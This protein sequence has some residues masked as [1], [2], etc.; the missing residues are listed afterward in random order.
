MLVVVVTG[1][2]PVVGLVSVPV[3]SPAECPPLELCVPGPEVGAV[4][5]VVVP[6]DAGAVVSGPGV[7][8]LVPPSSLHPAASVATSI[9]PRAYRLTVIISIR[10]FKQAGECTTARANISTVW[11]LVRRSAGEPAHVRWL[12]VLATPALISCYSQGVMSTPA[13]PSSLSRGLQLAARGLRIALASPEV[14]RAYVHLAAV[15]VALAVALTVLLGGLLWWMVPVDGDMS[16]TTWLGRWAL[17]VGGSLL[18]LMAA[19]MLALFVVNLG[20]PVLADRVFMAGMRAAAPELAARLDRPTGLGFVAS[21]VGNLRRGLRFL[22]VTIALGALALVPFV[23]PVLG[24]PLQLWYAARTL[25][26]ELLDPYFE[27]AGH[28]YPRQRGIVAA[29]RATLAGFGLPWAALM[30]LPLLGPLLFGLAQAAV[31]ALV[32]EELEADVPR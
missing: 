21:S 25:T 32:M 26:W 5:G 7:P 16:W 17:R 11:G 29:R 24:P 3:V 15:L 19:P 28:D 27:R 14:R 10:P 9:V 31:A 2:G 30:A 8:V 20:L 1:P 23:G 12:A 6:S 4:V 18:A 13:A 22:G